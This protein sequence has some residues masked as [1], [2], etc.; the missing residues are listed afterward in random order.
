MHYIAAVDA[1]QKDI[2]RVFRLLG[3]SVQTC[4]TLGKG[5]PDLHVGVDGIDQLV[6][7]KDGS[8]PPSARKLTV[9]EEK[10]HREWRGRPVVIV[11]TNEQAIAL[12][13]KIRQEKR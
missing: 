2:V 11:E 7:V 9:P 1:N 13:K 3:C 10:F 5:Y 6:E 8:K 4:H 12:V